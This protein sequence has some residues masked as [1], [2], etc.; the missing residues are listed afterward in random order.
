MA[1]G[2]ALALAAVAA[3]LAASADAAV[4]RNRGAAGADKDGGSVS[5]EDAVSDG[6]KD[7][8]GVHW[9]DWWDW[10]MNVARNDRDNW[11]RNR[12]W[13]LNTQSRATDEDK[14]AHAR[15]EAA[16]DKYVKAE[17]EHKA[18]ESEWK[19]V[20][21][22]RIAL[23]HQRDGLIKKV[24]EAKAAQS[25]L[26]H[27]RDIRKSEAD[28]LKDKKA[29]EDLSVA[30]L[31]AEIPKLSASLANAR[32]AHAKGVTA[33]AAKV[34]P[35]RKSIAVAARKLSALRT[36]RKQEAAV[37]KSARDEMLSEE[38]KLKADSKRLRRA[39]SEHARFAKRLAS[40]EAI[41][42]GKYNK[43]QGALHARLTAATAKVDESRRTHELARAELE[44]TRHASETDR[45][46][47]EHEAAA[48]EA[49]MA[50]LRKAHEA[51][52][53]QRHS[54]QQHLRDAMTAAADAAA[55]ATAK[56]DS[57]QTKRKAALEA[58]KVKEREAVLAGETAQ[59]EFEG[60]RTMRLQA[61]E[62]AHREEEKLAA[63]LAAAKTAHETV[64]ANL[65]TARQRV[66]EEI[67]QLEFRIQQEEIAYEGVRK[68]LEDQRN[69]AVADMTRMEADHTRAETTFNATIARLELAR[70]TA[71]GAL[72]ATEA[73]AKREREDARALLAK[74]AHDAEEAAHR[75]TAEMGAARK[76]EHAEMEALQGNLTALLARKVALQAEIR[77]LGV[78]KARFEAD[79][80]KVAARL[81]GARTALMAAESDKRAVSVT[82]AR[83]ESEEKA[84]ADALAE[85]KAA[86]DAAVRRLTEAN[87]EAEDLRVR[88]VAGERKIEALQAQKERVEANAA[89]IAKAMA[90]IRV[91]ASGTGASGGRA[92][93][94][95]LFKLGQRLEASQQEQGR[96]V[97]AAAAIEK[98]IAE[99]TASKA[100][101]DTTV[102]GLTTR[103]DGLKAA[104]VTEAG[105]DG[106]LAA[107]VQAQAALDA[108]HAAAARK[109][110]AAAAKR[111]DA[112]DAAAHAAAALRE[113]IAASKKAAEALQAQ[114]AALRG[115]ALPA[116]AQAMIAAARKELAA[117]TAADDAAMAAALARKSAEAAIPKDAL[118]HMDALHARIAKLQAVH[119]RAVEAQ[120]RVEDAAAAAADEAAARAAALAATPDVIHKT[121]VVL[122]GAAAEAAAP[123]G[124]AAERAA[125]HLP[126]IGV[127]IRAPAGNTDNVVV[128]GPQ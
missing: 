124:S 115:G 119:T 122:H 81:A 105:A 76:A 97:E 61:I 77:T 18:A 127:A 117:A 121:R 48:T 98:E 90:A 64:R 53:H 75:F 103:A 33:M 60:N 89:E 83:L 19:P 55:K 49:T 28:V 26:T 31:R 54:Q 70:G 80:E 13:W 106:A 12:D 73:T 67:K 100:T 82:V 111:T 16:H 114:L 40:K 52:V 63:R 42:A 126:N 46:L 93:A 22:A 35:I 108:A 8:S 27:Q 6:S 56:F 116:P 51:L 107:A 74:M 11:S 30:E 38:K 25:E 62:G 65:I 118:E 113:E 123:I 104:G 79:A 66:E 10:R 1:G 20:H 43:Y 72:A 94:D 44:R 24:G 88:R 45:K 9:W 71:E 92:I 7:G 36:Q 3:L 84:A 4:R 102:A 96:L 58:L 17:A 15:Y 23:Q 99:L 110:A 32:E 78:D 29:A 34:G 69:A 109:E 95:A 120:R 50:G 5:L 21:N 85:V 39:A 125:L 41:L 101:L 86:L 37:A 112:Q 57:A 2:R 47:A 87:H 68:R 14:R 59:R 91:D 128:R